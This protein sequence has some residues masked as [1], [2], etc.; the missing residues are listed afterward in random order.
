MTT[1]SNG[2]L[3]KKKRARFWRGALLALLLTALAVGLG[4]GIYFGYRFVKGWVDEVMGETAESSETET[5]SEATTEETEATTETAPL[6]EEE[7]AYAERL[8]ASYDYDAAIAYVKAIPNYAVYPE[9]NGAV[10]RFLEAKSQLVKVDITQIPHVFV[11]SLIYDTALAFSSEEKDGYN[12]TM[13]TL[14]EFKAMLEQMYARG[15]VLVRL[16][17]MAAYNSDGSFVKGSIMLPAD[18]KPFVLSIDDMVYYEYMEGDGFASRIVLDESGRPTCEMKQRDGSTV[19]GD[20]DLV[21]L[22]ESFI[23]AHPDFSY[24]GA[25]GAIALTG[26]DGI[27]GYRTAPKYAD[28]AG[29]DWKASYAAINVEQERQEAARVAARLKELGWEFASHSWGHVDMGKA[30]IGWIKTDTQKWKKQVDSLL[31]GD[32]DIMIFAYGADIGSWRNYSSDNEKFTYLKSV[33][34]SYFC[35][36]D[37]YNIPWVQFSQSQGYLRQGRVNLDGYEM[38]Y[39]PEKL[40]IF[41]DAAEVFDKSRPLPVPKY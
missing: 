40:S 16:H 19:T 38:Y 14:T 23:E 36:V 33:G 10:M 1:K 24:R 28:P 20:F 17:D 26:Y 5:G 13:T 21:P 4:A 7:L 6:F 31:G 2:Y 9:L 39:Y 35:N 11:H 32:T 12:Q 34:F 37:A 41:F 29:K 8:A 27:M 22:L 30:D 25:R 18:K 15:Y 3:K